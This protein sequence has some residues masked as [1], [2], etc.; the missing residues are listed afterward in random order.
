MVAVPAVQIRE[1]QHQR[2]RQR[3]DKRGN[4][5]PDFEAAA[6]TLGHAAGKNDRNDRNDKNDQRDGIHDARSHAALRRI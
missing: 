1:Q 3:P 4:P 5:R 6:S 2:K